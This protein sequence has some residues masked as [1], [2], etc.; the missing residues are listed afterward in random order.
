MD[1]TPEKVAMISMAAKHELGEMN[2]EN[3]IIKEATA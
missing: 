1:L 3:L 2:L